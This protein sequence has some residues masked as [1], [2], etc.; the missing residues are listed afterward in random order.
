[1]KT[2]EKLNFI[3]NITKTSN[4][5]LSKRISLDASHISRLRRGERRLVANAE[6]LK[7][8]MLYFAKQCVE[9]YQKNALS[10]ALGETPTLFDDLDMAAEHLCIW[11]LSDDKTESASVAGFLDEL[12]NSKLAGLNNYVKMNTS[13]ETLKTES[14]TSLY[15]GVEGKREAVIRFLSIVL[16]KDKPGD[17]LL[18]SDESM[19]W[20]TQNKAFQVLWMNLMLRVIS[21]G[22]HI[23]IIHN[24]NRNLNEM[25]EA[26]S[27]WIPLYMTGAIEPY[28]YPK[29]RDGVCRRTMFIALGKAALSANSY[30]NM[31]GNA[32]N[33]L[34]QEKEAIDA[35][36]DE[37]NHYVSLCRP[38]MRV[39]TDISSDDY[40]NTLAEFEKETEN[41]ILKTEGLSL[42][43]MPENVVRSMIERSAI[44]DKDR[45][46]GI[47]TSRREIFLQGIQKN[48]FNEIIKID[49]VKS[50]MNGLAEIGHMGMKE[51]FGLK[52]TVEEYIDHLKNIVVLLKSYENY[53]ITFS[54]EN[55]N[56]EHRLYVKEDLGVIVDKTTKPHV[57]FAINEGNMTASFWDYLNDILKANMIDKKSAIKRI[58]A[59]VNEL[60]SKAATKG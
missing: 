11:V 36:A 44:Q 51:L 4:S 60:S 32:M 40:I 12:N 54:K 35:V 14:N 33:I 18:Y 22:N 31:T 17:L 42:L 10:E 38:L 23:K 26:L 55:N 24:V 28:Y 39:Y 45:L 52:Y 6:Y 53:N 27:K 46:M 34:Y 59:R 29:K 37:F 20:I 47:F 58:E 49:N 8:M 43:T 3:M 7:K 25:L 15:Y 48:E 16:D 30:D 21:K 41:T 19:D 2:S 5:S 56:D 57:A 1:M 9:D 13:D 50:I